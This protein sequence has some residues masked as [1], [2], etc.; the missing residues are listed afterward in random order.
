MKIL[1]SGGHGKFAQAFLR[2]NNGRHTIYA[3]NKATLDVRDYWSI[4]KIIEDVQPDIF[5]HAAAFTRPMVKHERDPIIS[6]ESNII[7]TGNVVIACMRHDV[8][9]VY[10]STDYVYP[11][12]KGDY[13]E[14]DPLKPF[15][16]YGWSKLGGECSVHMYD[17]SLIL[18]I[19]MNNRPFPHPKA[20]V[21]IKKSLIYDDEAAEIT[22][23]LLDEKGIINVGGIGRSIYEFAKEDNPDIGKMYYDEVKD[24]GMAKNTTL[25]IE[26]MKEIV[27]GCKSS[28]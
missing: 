18:R 6:I 20:I 16:R 26:K 13:N 5:L 22:H 3:P 15:N 2:A 10:I 27:N 12:T 17:N 1:I 21:D 25:N 8:K 7:G 19:C 11:G 23:E 14:D 9:L 28:R 24:V 4:E